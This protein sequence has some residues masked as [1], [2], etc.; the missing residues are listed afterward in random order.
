MVA[1]ARKPGPKHACPLWIPISCRT[2]PLTMTAWAAPARVAVVE[3]ELA[4]VCRWARTAAT[5]TGKYSGR[6]P[7]ITALMAA[8]SAVTV[9]LRVGTVPRTSSGSRPPAA[10]M[11]DT[12]SAVAG[13]TGRPSVHPSSKQ[14]SSASSAVSKRAGGGAEGHE[15]WVRRARTAGAI[16]SARASASSFVHTPVG[17]WG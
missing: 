12:A 17:L 15:G 2:G 9:T 3:W 4:L 13:T 14:A 10:S 8:F 16:S 5:T 11:A 1:L 6:H 7:A